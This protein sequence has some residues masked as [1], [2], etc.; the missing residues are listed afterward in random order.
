VSSKMSIKCSICNKEST[1]YN[2]LGFSL[3]PKCHGYFRDVKVPNHIPVDQW[4]KYQLLVAKGR[5]ENNR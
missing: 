1:T 3:C 4:Y 2:Y 5:F